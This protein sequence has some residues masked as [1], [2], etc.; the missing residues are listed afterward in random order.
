[1][2][3]D[4]KEGRKPQ[5]KTNFKE[6]HPPKDIHKGRQPQRQTASKE[7]N[8]NFLGFVVAN[9]TNQFLAKFY[10]FFIKEIFP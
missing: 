10:P 5:R 6:R 8:L 1:M 2:R 7:N 3:R 9:V 4:S